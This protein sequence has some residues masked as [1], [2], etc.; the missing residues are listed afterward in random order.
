[1]SSQQ[2]GAIRLHFLDIAPLCLRMSALLQAFGDSLN[3]A[4]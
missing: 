1:M 3:V 2:V 4:I